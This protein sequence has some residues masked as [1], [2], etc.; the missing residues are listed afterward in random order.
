MIRFPTKV[1]L[2]AAGALFTAGFV[3]WPGC[4]TPP[5]PASRTPLSSLKR[6]DFSFVKRVHPNR[7]EIVSKLG[8]PDLYFA[9]LEVACYKLNEIKRSRLCLLFG[10][11]PIYAFR[12]PGCLEVAMI[13]YDDHHRAQQCEIRIIPQFYF[14]GE[15]RLYGDPAKIPSEELRSMMYSEA[16]RWLL[17]P[18]STSDRH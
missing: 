12:D 7:E 9:D 11:L 8:K 10:I 2:L 15:Y 1:A 14:L 17:K 16:E 4:A 5:L 18:P 3:V 6:S 13:Q